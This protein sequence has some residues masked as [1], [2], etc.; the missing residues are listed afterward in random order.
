MH[1]TD[2][3]IRRPVLASAVSLLILLFGLFAA[4]KL[5]L[6]LFPK[7][8]TPLITITTNY[9]GADAKTMQAYVTSTLE[10]A[11]AGIEGINYLTAS[12]AQGSSAINI[13][14]Q[15][16][17]SADTAL[18]NIMVK[19]AA[20]RSTLPKA[21]DDPVITKSSADDD[22]AMIIAFTSRQMSREQMGDYLRRVIEPKLEAVDGVATAQV[23]GR[24]YAMR[25]WLDPEQMAAR[26]VTAT[27]VS[28]ALTQQN[29]QAA[30]GNTKGADVN[31]AVDVNSELRQAADFNE[32]IIKKDKDALV[33]LKDIGNAELGPSSDKIGAVFNGERAAMIFIKLL[34]AANP[35]TVVR[36]INNLLPAINKALPYDLQAHVVIDA[37]SYIK[38]SIKEVIKALLSAALIVIVVIF[39]F[40]ASLRAV[41]IPVVTLPLSLIGA[42]CI[43]WLLNYSI[44]T[45]TLL[46]MVLAIGLVVDDAIVVV[47]NIL[48]R[49]EAGQDSYSA[50]LASAR[51]VA[52]P[53][54]A[55]TITLAA[56]YAPIGFVGGLTG[57]LFAEFAFTLAGAVIISGIV[58]LTL[59]PMM[60]ARLL[61]RQV[62]ENVFSRQV[63]NF[64]DNFR[65]IYLALLN[66]ILIKRTLVMVVWGVALLGCFFCYA[67]TPKE[68]A[69]SED[70][71]FL[72]VISRAPDF[73][74]TN[75]LITYSNYLNKV[76]QS[77]SAIDSYVYVDGIPDE[78]QALSFLSLKPWHDRVENSAQLLPKL[79]EKLNSISGIQSIVIT[80]L[81]LPGSDGLPLQFVLTTA[82]GDYL[83]LYKLAQ[84]LQA[85]ARESGL[86]VFLDSDLKFAA[87]HLQ[88]SIDRDAAAMLGVPISSIT[89]ALNLFLSGNKLQQ[90][91]MDGRSYDV[92]TQVPQ[93]YR[94]NP[95][96]LDQYSV[97]TSSGALVPLSGVVNK[98]ISVEPESI[99][100]FQKYNAVMLSG[101]MAPGHTLSEGLH[102]LKTQTA[103]IAPRDVHYDYAGESRQFLQEGNRML[104]VFG[105]AFVVIFLVLAIQFESYRVPLVILFGSVPMSLFGALLLLRLGVATINIYTQVGLLTLAGLISKHGILLANFANQLQEKE[106]LKPVDAILKAAQFRLRPILMTT[107]AIVFGALPLIFAQ[108]AGAESRFDMG[109]VIAVGMLL[110]TCFTLFVVPVLYLLLASPCPSPAKSWEK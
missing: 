7:V 51:E 71:G 63:N 69:P 31:F 34:P 102:F 109:V 17:Q 38:E 104:F 105:M 21:I 49:I 101:V 55:M 76:Y 82:A 25:I 59:S 45:L 107:A 44:N 88:I 10:N 48:R 56:V 84:R 35:I 26:N 86:F 89:T 103:K 72:Q 93:A 30:A 16:G 65:G 92:I 68:L 42:C 85:E 53:I 46:A 29:I 57:E 58:A 79:Q 77:F 106:N 78:H 110:G 11:V 22:Q 99:N 50:A 100:Q 8:E 36:E 43:M 33:K 90:F 23:L 62:T 41:I 96:A 3:F 5:P 87:P 40:T 39:L 52:S 12:T 61:S 14:L 73:T 4:T 27:D 80:P 37:G 83:A 54:I 75:F 47:E 18:T 13:Y 67:T 9:P 91:S 95:A 2:I 1:L 98:Q 19:I 94:L 70:Q 20:V 74:N 66:K 108:D 28:Q 97:R 15:I 60:S 81:A 24:S 64:L 32:I 6:R